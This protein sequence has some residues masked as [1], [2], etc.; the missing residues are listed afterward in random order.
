MKKQSMLYK[1]SAV[2]L[3]LIFAHAQ[4]VWS[5]PSIDEIVSGD[6]TVETLNG[7][8]M[9]INASANSIIN[10]TT[11]NIAENESVVINLPSSSDSIL[12]RVTGGMISELLGDLTCN[13]MFLLVN[14]AGIHVGANAALNAAGIMLSTRD[15]NNA[16]F[17][18]GDYIFKRLS[19]SELNGMILNEGTIA[20][21]TGGFINFISGA[22]ENRGTILAPLGKI[23]LAGGDHVEID[24]SGEGRVYVAIEE[25][26]ATEILDFQGNPITDQIKNTGTIQANG[27]IVILDAESIYDIFDCAINLEGEIKAEAMDD[28]EGVIRLIADGDMILNADIKATE[29]KVGDPL[30]KVPDN[31]LLKGGHL[32]AEKLIEIYA[33]DDLSIYGDLVV[34]QGDIRIEYDYDADGVGTVD[35]VLGLLQVRKSG[36]VYVNGETIFDHT[37]PV[38]FVQNIGQV[39][40]EEVIYYVIAGDVV[41]Y[42]T[43]TEVV[44][45]LMQEIETEDGKMTAWL[46]IYMEFIGANDDTE[47]IAGLGA[48]SKYNYLIGDA[49]KHKNNVPTFLDITYEYIYEGIDLTYE[50]KDGVLESIYLVRPG[51][52]PSEIRGKYNGIEGIELDEAGNLIVKTEAGELV[53]MAPYAYQE[54]NGEIVEVAC[55]FVVNEDGTY[56][57]N[58]GEYDVSEELIIDPAIEYSTYIGSTGWESGYGVTIDV[59]KNI[60]VV[61]STQGA[62][63]TSIGG[64][65]GNDIYVV[66]MSSDLS[67]MLYST[68]IGGSLNEQGWDIVADS[69]GC[70]YIAGTTA[71]LDFPIVNGFETTYGG[72]TK[73]VVVFKLSQDGSSLLYSTYLGGSGYDDT[74]AGIAMDPLGKI[75][76]SGRTE[77][78]DFPTT[79]GAYDVSPN[80]SSDAWVAKI[81]TTLSGMTSLVYSTYLGG[82]GFDLSCGIEVDDQGYAYV[83]GK[84]GN[85]TFPYTAGA[86]LGN[87]GL[88]SGGFITKLTPDGSGLVYSAAFGSSNTDYTEID[89]DSY[90]NA[91]VFGY[92]VVATTPGSFMSS[93]PPTA[94]SGAQFLL[95][96]NP[97]GDNIVFSTYLGE[98]PAP[99]NTYDGGLSVDPWGYTWVSWGT[100]VAGQF[101]TPDAISATK[102]APNALYVAKVSQDGS[103]LTYASYLGGTNATT[104]YYMPRIGVDAD[105]YVYLV[106]YTT[107]TDY[108]T[109]PGVYSTT[110][111]GGGDIY[112]T[113]IN[114]TDGDGDGVP[115]SSDL[116]PTDGT[117]WS[118]VDGDGTG[119]N[120]DTDDD[121]DGVLDVNDAFPNDPAE[122]SD[123]DGDGIGDN[124]DTD[125]DNDGVLDVNDAFPLDA[126]EDTDTDS[127]GQGDNADTD[128][129]NDGVLDVNDDFPLDATEDTDTDSDGTGDN[130]D[131]DDDND[132]V[133]DV[134]DAFPLDAT[135]D[136]DTDSDGQGD[137][138]D[139]DDD[140]DGVLDVND[141]FPLDATEDTD[142]DSDGTGDNADTDDDNDGVLDVNDAFPLDATEDTDTD[143][144][145]IGNNADTDDDNDGVLDVNDA[146]PLDATEDTDTDSDGTGDNADTDDD[147]DG[148]LDVNDAFPLD[149][150]E[151]TDTDSDGTGDNADTDDDNDGVLDVNDAF[152]LDATEDTDTDSD[153]IGNNADTDDDNDGYSDQDEIDN[154]VDPLDDGATPPDND[155]DKV[156]DLNDTDDDND[157]VLDVND[158]FPLD[159]TEDTDTDSDGTGDNAD[160]DDDNDGVLDVNDA[161]PLDATEDTDTDSDGQGDNADTDD[162]N[163]GVLD[164]ND[165]FPLDA[166]EDTDTDSD[167]QGDNA[168]TDDD[169]D[170]VL[171]VNDAFPLDATEDT[172]T[173][174]DG[175]GDNAD[176]DDDNDGVLDVNDDFPL[177]ATEDTD[178]DSDGTGDNAD[179]DDDNDGVLDVNDAFPLDATEDTDTDSDGQGDNA[180]TDDDNDGVLDVNDDFPLDATEDTD[181][182]SDGTG[183]NADTDDDNDGVLDV[184]DAFPLDATEDT[185]TDSDGTGDNAD[186]DDDNDG[187][188]D[189]ND[190]FP[191]DAT[192]DTDTDGDGI[193]NNADLDDDGDGI[194]DATDT[195]NDNDGVPDAQDAFPYDPT[196]TTDTD[197]DG[198]GD[199][200]D[201]FPNDATETVD[202]DGDGIGDNADLDD[203]GDGVLDVNDDFP[204]DA[205]ET[206]DTDGD[207]VGDNSDAFPNDA[208]ETVDTD[209]DGIGDNADLDDDGDG[210]LDVNDDFPTD[211]TE[212]TDTDGDGIGDNSDAFPNDATETVDTDGDGIGDNADLDDDGD[213]VLDINDDFP[214]DAT[215]T[216]D[217]DGDGIGDNADT[218]DD[219]DGVPDFQDIAPL[220]PSISSSSSGI[221]NEIEVKVNDITSTLPDNKEKARDYAAERIG[222]T[223]EDQ[224]DMSNV[225][226]FLNNFGDKER[227]ENFS[228]ILMENPEIEFLV[229]KAGLDIEDL[230]DIISSDPTL[231]SKNGT[232]DAGRIRTR[233]NLIRTI[234]DN[235]VVQ[236]FSED[237]GMQAEDLAI[238]LTMD[239]SLRKKYGSLD[240][241]KVKYKLTVARTLTNSKE[242]RSLSVE[243]GV[244]PGELALKLALDNK[245]YT[246][247]KFDISKLR[248]YLKTI[249][250]ISKIDI[251]RRYSK[252]TEINLVDLCFLLAKDETLYTSGLVD[253]PKVETRVLAAESI[254]Y[255]EYTQSYSKDIDMNTGV[256]SL[257]LA[258]DESLY[259]RGLINKGAVAKKLGMAKTII[260][261][262]NV[263]EY[264]RKT[265][266]QVGEVGLVISGEDI[267]EEGKISDKKI[268]NLIGSAE[269]AISNDKIKD[270][271]IKAGVGLGQ[272]GL[273]RVSRKRHLVLDEE[274]SKFTVMPLSRFRKE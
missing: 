208:T 29:I 140:N 175:Q 78:G 172:D 83:T 167:G 214:N 155:G 203:D 137:N 160:T 185:D 230:T 220:N 51:A 216:V 64:L 113:I 263:R 142:T 21:H 150:T 65:G 14:T 163:D 121:N 49:S 205:T 32:D 85:S 170:G 147:N 158:A 30:D 215:E 219:N 31:V 148:V 128:D 93:I 236:S 197:G 151:D 124:A 212:T 213:G 106:G 101:T 227:S 132:G 76:V 166:T 73:D 54:V 206:T 232:L 264:S 217:T 61:G 40:D 66:K 90:G 156:S 34:T 16:D 100:N 118:D 95:K 233:L 251:V 221:P 97:G 193:G 187:V 82:S 138:A 33:K 77:S 169:N 15:I 87:L 244:E 20:V 162:D 57:Y 53:E 127:D 96:L 133:L 189:V 122:T 182:D 164:V 17:L 267:L 9:N 188:L 89:I 235:E 79:L 39:E 259:R 266:M 69:S 149:A 252:R 176:T 1:I 52:D 242:I 11:F 180:D 255:N 45:L 243:L 18:R 265:G 59:N 210:V 72:G 25:E 135:E 228:D 261:D 13:G 108:P 92:G 204:T 23:A 152:P 258:A 47:I 254:L 224:G 24:I 179:T 8:T 198:V 173:D 10:Y 84:R 200:S 222:W 123:S 154:G 7:N 141:D 246:E 256:L 131:T 19:S 191:L 2:I 41:Y 107:S 211:A 74:L 62:V 126:T 68:I 269:R 240:M 116:F 231:F 226:A 117:E 104:G 234:L 257:L 238:L 50:S 273:M 165:A 271:S 46:P 161:F 253:I 268:K 35:H 94:T 159:A 110:N 12:N 178:T 44:Y 3:I 86:Y 5:L 55:S 22:I 194:P 245:L 171:D 71:S 174:S 129:D 99:Y 192:E 60:Y 56:A 195:D 112:V 207:G 247:G 130:A 103:E 177:D 199:N 260:K 4:C 183:D 120:A 27:G 143:S 36:D 186:T 38:Y 75:Y 153:G 237:N 250:D 37:L 67:T 98:H 48:G 190:D 43:E 6:V 139:T 168:D 134:N 102:P 223:F 241:A 239:N 184:N 58:V 209:G 109:T 196:E 88:S 272:L 218:D 105:G 28:N 136:T 81:D 249:R 181:T 111:A 63:P 248:D 270:F 26:T 70:A 125:D 80:G 262:K 115:N 146:F 145:G 225:D 229:K 114:D 91:Y 202:T 157:G 274:A 144:D 119:D 42:F 201:A